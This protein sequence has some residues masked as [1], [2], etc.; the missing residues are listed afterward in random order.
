[1]F[2]GVPYNIACYSTLLMILAK[3]TGC[4]PRTLYHTVGNAHVYDNHA[5][6]VSQQL[7][8]K[9]YNSP[10]LILK[11]DFSDINK[12]TKDQFELVGYEHHPA[13]RGKVAV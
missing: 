3:A 7:D 9:P 10:K 12:I 6:L 1:M 13:L 11:G 2:L 4:D 5:I 8:R